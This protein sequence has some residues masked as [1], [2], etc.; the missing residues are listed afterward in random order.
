MGEL[1]AWADGLVQKIL[2]WRSLG[3][4]ACTMPR[5]EQPFGVGSAA[6]SPSAE[7]AA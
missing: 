7:E 1:C 3:W 6:I 2:M 4:R 5:S